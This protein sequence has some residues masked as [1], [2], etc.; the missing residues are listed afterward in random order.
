M[1]LDGIT[2]CVQYDAGGTEFFCADDLH[3]REKNGR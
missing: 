2:I 3:H 1:T